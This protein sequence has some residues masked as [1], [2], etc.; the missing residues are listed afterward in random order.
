[1]YIYIYIYIYN[2]LQSQYWPHL[3][4]GTN[5]HKGGLKHHQLCLFLKA[6]L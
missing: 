3:F 6:L 4:I 2:L 1:M 5:V